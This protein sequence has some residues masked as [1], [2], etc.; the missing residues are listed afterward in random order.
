MSDSNGIL[1][2][3]DLNEREQQIR[4]DYEWVLHDPTVQ[5]EY[6]GKVVIVYRQRILGTGIDHLAAIADA[7]RHEDCPPICDLAKVFVEGSPLVDS[8]E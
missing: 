8:P 2:S 4:D 3:T 7:K 1:K 5:Q 6:A